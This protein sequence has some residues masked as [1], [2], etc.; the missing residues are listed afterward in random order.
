MTEGPTSTY[1]LQAT[2]VSTSRLQL[3]SSSL[4]PREV[5]AGVTSSS[6][7]AW[8]FLGYTMKILCRRDPLALRRAGMLHHVGVGTTVS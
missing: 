3:P 1:S 6:P 7:A 4:R 8:D 5:D 2:V